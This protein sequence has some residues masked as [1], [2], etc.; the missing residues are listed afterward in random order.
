VNLPSAAEV[1]KIR[2][3]DRNQALG[4]AAIYATSG[5]ARAVHHYDDANGG[6]TGNRADAE[7][8]VAA[9]DRIAHSLRCP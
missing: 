3:E 1:F 4:W 5:M 7:A 2:A 8:I 9:G 6:F